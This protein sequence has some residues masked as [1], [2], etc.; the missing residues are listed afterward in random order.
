MMHAK[1]VASLFCECGG[2]MIYQ[3]KGKATTVLPGSFEHRCSRCETRCMIR[4]QAFPRARSWSVSPEPV[5][6]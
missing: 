3:P 4:G 6:G 1:E 5:S 2:E